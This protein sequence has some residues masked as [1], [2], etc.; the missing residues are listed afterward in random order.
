MN[1]KIVFFE[2]K[3]WHFYFSNSGI[4][5]SNPEENANTYVVFDNGYF[6]FDVVCDEKAIHLLCQDKEGAVIYFTYTNSEWHKKVIFLSKTSSPYTKSFKL[7]LSKSLICAIY[8]IVKDSRPMLVFQH[9]NTAAAPFVIDYITSAPRSFFALAKD[10]FDIDIYY[11]NSSGILGFKNYVWSKK[12]FGSFNALCDGCSSPFS[13]DSAKTAA[14]AGNKIVFF[15]NNIQSEVYNSYGIELSAPF[16]C[17]INEEIFVMW[18]QG[19]M[20]FYSKKLKNGFSPPSRFV[21]PFG[22]PRIFEIKTTLK[23]TV[24]LYGSL[25]QNKINLLSPSHPLGLKDFFSQ[26]ETPKFSDSEKIDIILKRLNEIYSLLG[27]K[28]F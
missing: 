18:Q 28:N 24:Y 4:C 1:D 17:K 20:T 7:I 13:V 15:E 10:N 12:E 16:C 22:L 2:N 26:N 9:L 19:S 21:L 8:T 14:L 3:I 11:Q 6:D 25:S 27:G 23:D 5:V